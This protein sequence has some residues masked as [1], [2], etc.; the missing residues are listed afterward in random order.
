MATIVELHAVDMVRE[1]VERFAEA[2]R[3]RSESDPVQRRRSKRRYQRSWPLTIRYDGVQLSA[4]LHNAS[5]EGIAFLSCEAIRPGTVVF[6]R[7][8][9]YDDSAAYV[10]A[11]V[12]HSTNT[13]HG[14][15]VGCEF[16]IWDEP[17]C[18][19]ALRHTQSAA[20]VS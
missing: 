20:E 16:A 5:E 3:Q 17:L 13:D 4:A 15:L 1:A 2:I 7:L 18:L 12:R 9:C 19:E 6:L 14:H 10:P 11:V 8:F